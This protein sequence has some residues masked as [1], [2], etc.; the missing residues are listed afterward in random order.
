MHMLACLPVCPPRYVKAAW[1]FR[2]AWK[3][4]S[5][6]EAKVAAYEGGGGDKVE[7]EATALFG[8]GLFHLIISLLPPTV[9]RVAKWAGFAEGDREVAIQTLERSGAA[10]GLLSIFSTLVVIQYNV[11]ISSFICCQTPDM[12]ETGGRLMEEVR[13]SKCAK[14]CYM[15]LPSW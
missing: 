12:V 7:L 4:F 9:M 5:D 15:L 10:G 6:C 8:V 1:N 13:S 11:V 2:K 14:G 3:Y